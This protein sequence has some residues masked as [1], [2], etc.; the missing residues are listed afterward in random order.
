MEAPGKYPLLPPLLGRLGCREVGG[1]DGCLEFGLKLL[2]RVRVRVRVGLGLHAYAHYS[3]S[4]YLRPG[5][6]YF[7]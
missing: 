2:V 6:G 3:Y 1:V 5:S 7:W 4:A